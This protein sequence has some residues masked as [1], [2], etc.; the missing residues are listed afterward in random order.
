MIFRSV[1]GLYVLC[2]VATADPAAVA[3]AAFAGGCRLFQLRAK[4]VSY[5]EAVRLGRRAAAR[6]PGAVWFANDDPALVAPLAAAGVHLG[7]SDGP[8]G[9]AREAM[10]PGAWVAR[11]CNGVAAVSAA[12]EEGAD[13]VAVGPVWDTPHLSRPKAVQGVDV[14]R[15]AVDL[16]AGRVPVVAIG[17]IRPDRVA[18]VRLAG[19]SAWA[20]IRGV[21]GA[22]DPKAATRAFLAS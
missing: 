7:A 16:V 2:D 12:L 17:G 4:G 3:A 9:R 14:L 15:R 20:V 10:P 19:A 13:V 22:P 1:R 18:Q 6:T 5:D 11:S 21:A 8:V